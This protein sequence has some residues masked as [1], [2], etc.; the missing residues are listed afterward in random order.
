MGKKEK[1]GRDSAKKSKKSTNKSQ[2]DHNATD[3]DIV[4]DLSATLDDDGTLH[5]DGM[6]LS[7]DGVVAHRDSETA[8]QE[9]ATELGQQL[10]ARLLDAAGGRGFLA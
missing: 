9:D 10:G 8:P 4:K 2:S 3:G 5:L 6:V 7:P 1:L